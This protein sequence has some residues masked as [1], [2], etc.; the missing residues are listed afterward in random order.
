M[1]E[2]VINQNDAVKGMVRAAIAGVRDCI[3]SVLDRSF[4]NGLDFPMAR[5]K[6]FDPDKALD[7]AVRVFW[8]QGFEATSIENLV[9]ELGIS[10]QSLYETFGSK[11]RLYQLSL[12]RYCRRQADALL[13]LLAAPGPLA[14]LLEVL[15]NSIVDEMVADCECKGCFV[16]N[17]AAERAPAEVQTRE[18]VTEQFALVESAFES[19]FHRAQTS[20][21]LRADANPRSLARF[22]L[23]AVNGLRILGKATPNR[24]VLADIATTTLR[25]LP[26]NSD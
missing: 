3:F 25:T 14:P 12:A 9:T 5:P 13:E 1:N 15:L 8:R 20:G 7:A 18:R 24:E 26:F 16:V 23:A 2:R 17:A 11:E 21:E 6:E 4:H 10:R 19:A 22:L